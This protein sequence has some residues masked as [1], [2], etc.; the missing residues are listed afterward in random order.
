MP[1]TLEHSSE[2]V[3]GLSCC[4]IVFAVARKIDNPFLEFHKALIVLA[5]PRL[6]PKRRDAKNLRSGV[7]VD[8][9]FDDL[10]LGLRSVRSHRSYGG[11][12]EEHTSELQSLR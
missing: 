7:I 11:R 2:I 3:N 6:Q 5:L 4:G 1:S 12:S 8:R 9:S 10:H